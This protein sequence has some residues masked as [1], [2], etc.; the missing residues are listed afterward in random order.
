MKVCLFAVLLASC[1]PSPIAP[2]TQPGCP[3]ACEQGAALDCSWA[4]PGCVRW[5]SAY[6][7]VGYMRPFAECVSQA[8]DVEAVTNCGVSC[9]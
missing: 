1:T 3:G 8:G 4:G 5:C 7:G 9:R 6:E 2:A